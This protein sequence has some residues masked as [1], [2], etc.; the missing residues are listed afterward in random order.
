MAPSDGC[1]QGKRQTDSQPARM[2]SA[3]AEAVAVEE[4]TGKSTQEQGSEFSVAVA[5]AA[6]HPD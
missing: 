3:G 6:P 5:A 1:C 2:V 4:K